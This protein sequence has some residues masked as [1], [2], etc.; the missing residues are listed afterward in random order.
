[1]PKPTGKNSKGVQF[2][3]PSGATIWSAPTLDLKRK[4]V[5]IATGNGYSGPEIDTADAVIALDMDTGKIKWKHQI[6]SDMFNWGCGRGG[7]PDTNCPENA[8]IDIDLGG[9][10]VLVDI[11]GGK[12]V[13]VQGRKSATAHG[14]D[15]DTGKQVWEVRIGGGGAGGGIQWAIAAGAG[16]GFA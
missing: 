13:L 6:G 5:Y 10:P 9:S 4:T 2:Y 8:G 3:G 14:L 1:E 12:Q 7:V 15:P 11:A 16:L